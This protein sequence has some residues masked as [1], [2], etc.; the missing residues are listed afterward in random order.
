M[1]VPAC[2]YFRGEAVK[3]EVEYRLSG[4]G[5]QPSAAASPEQMKLTYSQVEREFGAF[6][7]FGGI[8]RKR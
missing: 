4:R 3:S 2:F 5:S 6:W 8:F 1:G 7:P